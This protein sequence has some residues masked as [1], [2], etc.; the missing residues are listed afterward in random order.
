[1][2][3]AKRA[4][5]LPDFLAALLRTAYLPEELPPAV[6]SRFFA[7][8]CKADFNH[9][10]GQQETIL[11]KTTVYDTF[12]APRAKS[13]RRNLAL[14]H[15]VAQLG[16]SLLITQHRNIIKSQIS[17]SGTSL[18]RT[19]EDPHNGKAFSGLDF[20]KRQP[21]A[22]QLHSE[23]PFILQ[24]DIS[25]FFYTA[26]THSIPWAILSKDKVKDWLQHDRQRLRRHWS[27]KFDTALQSCQSRETFGIPVGP[28]TSRIIAEI[29]L[30]GVEA[31][32]ILK[33]FLK[34]GR[35]FRLL[36]DFMM[37]F[38]NE[39]QARQALTALRNALWKYNLQLND[40]KTKITHSHLLFREKWQLDF[41]EIAISNSHAPTQR[42]EIQR[43][44]DLTLNYCADTNI[45]C[46][47]LLIKSTHH[48]HH[49]DRSMIAQHT[50]F[51]WWPKSA[52]PN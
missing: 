24:A 22:A 50:K 21:L 31:D 49:Q 41:D 13:G 9:L 15:P 16:V 34:Q 23:F 4:S 46:W 42:R 48:K 33:P 11:R 5:K 18:Y 1:M 2:A 43:M 27:N 29:L 39:P 8:F 37:G 36:D 25:R 35:A 6:T 38:M 30:S 40:D 7:D 52:V 20:R 47:A 12:T 3:A 28:D 32:P 26:Y 44:V 45:P 17:K 19:N 51:H 10:R 14:V